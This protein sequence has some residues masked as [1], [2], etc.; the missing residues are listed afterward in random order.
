MEKET[1]ITV[2]LPISISILSAMKTNNPKYIYSGCD[3]GIK[4]NVGTM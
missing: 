4:K 1:K 3:A 2:N